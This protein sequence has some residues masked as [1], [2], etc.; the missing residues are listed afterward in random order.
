MQTS[1]FDELRRGPVVMRGMSL[2]RSFFVV[3]K[4]GVEHS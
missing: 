3:L 4:E 2:L 1:G